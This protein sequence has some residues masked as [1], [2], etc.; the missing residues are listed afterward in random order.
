MFSDCEVVKTAVGVDNEALLKYIQDNLNGTIPY[1]YRASEGRMIITDGKIYGD[2]NISLFDFDNFTFTPKLITFNEYIISLEKVKFEFPKQ[3]NFKTTLSKKS[4]LRALEEPEKET[5][6]LI[7]NE[8]NEATAK[9]LCEIYINNSDINTIELK[10]NITNFNIK[11]SPFASEYVSNLTKIKDDKNSAVNLLNKESYILQ[12][13][14]FKKSGSDLVISGYLD[15]KDLPSFSK[16]ELT[17]M[18]SELPKNNKTNLTCTVEKGADNKYDLVCKTKPNTSYN[19]EN[20]L[21]IDNNKMLIVNFP[22]GANTIA[23]VDGTGTDT[24]GATRRFYKKSSSGLKPG[25]IALIVIIPI[26]LIAAVV[27]LILLL[28]KLPVIPNHP[29]PSIST[30]EN[31]IKGT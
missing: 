9:Y 1:K 25:L 3:L 18:V 17:L 20:S 23:K 14:S 12:D 29:I 7:Q 19:L 2:I 4:R 10:P 16:N 21:L 5:L 15:N 13:A 6:C 31:I 8:V 27:T 30:T 26:V 28:R 24:D 22:E 11:I